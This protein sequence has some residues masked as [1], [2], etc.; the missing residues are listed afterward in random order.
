V[1]HPQTRY[2]RRGE[3][4]IAYQTVGGPGPDLIIVPGFISHLDLQWTDLGFSRF[5]ERLASFTR[6]ILYDKPGTGLSDPIPHV[7]TLEERIADI[8]AVLDAVG[9]E[10]TA[11]LGFSEGGPTCALFAATWPERTSALI[12]Y[13]SFARGRWTDEQLRNV[14]VT[15]SQYDRVMSGF[16]GILDHWGEGRLGRLIAPSATGELQRRFWAIFERAGASPAMARGLVEATMRADVT[17]VL[18]TIQAPTLV[19]HRS[20]DVFPLGGGRHLAEEIPGARLVELEGE[21]HAFWF[22]DIEPILAEVEEFLT[23]VRTAAAPDRLLATVLFTDIVGSTELASRLGDRGWH[24]LIEE[25][26]ARV[27]ELLEL[28]GGRE[29]DTAGDG[30]FASFEGPG[31]A[32]R[33]A[34][35]IGRSLRAFGVEIR[36][37]VHTG[38]CERMG[39]KLGGLAVHVGARIAALANGGEVLASRT[40]RDLVAGSGLKFTDR[41]THHLRGVDE[42][43]QL[44]AVDDTVSSTPQLSGPLE[45][46]SATDRALVNIARRAP[47]VLRLGARMGGIK[48]PS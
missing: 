19:L 34:C 45:H 39:E 26:D 10:R 47:A 48:R 41:G 7:P 12:L 25:H 21:D 11:L 5:L 17:A 16:A 40:V 37:G 33:C 2:V 29:L 20:G 28:F 9:S 4:S 43:W 27:R 6:L 31:A 35:A 8:R 24:E 1:Q 23:G 22:G 44:F 15:R 18:R 13:G 32:V 3:V 30:F 36:A 46:L 14:G 42:P 38:E